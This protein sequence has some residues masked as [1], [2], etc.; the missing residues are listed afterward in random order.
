M[1]ILILGYSNRNSHG[2]SYSNTYNNSLVLA[3]ETPNWD[4]HVKSVVVEKQVHGYHLSLRCLK[5]SGEGILQT[6]LGAHLKIIWGS[7]LP[8]LFGVDLGSG[9]PKPN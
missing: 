6:M 7:C 1:I 3:I 9:I 4:L 8:L 2:N 5:G